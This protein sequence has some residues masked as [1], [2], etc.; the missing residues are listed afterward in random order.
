MLHR[1]I[2]YKSIIKWI[3]ISSVYTVH[4]YLFWLFTPVNN[5]KNS[6]SR[7][8]YSTIE[9]KTLDFKGNFSWTFWPVWLIFHFWH[10]P[11][12]SST[13]QLIRLLSQYAKARNNEILHW[14]W[15]VRNYTTRLQHL[16][17]RPLLKWMSEDLA[18]MFPCT[19]TSVS[20]S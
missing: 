8:L 1:N 10:A 6:S 7:W 12:N 5:S 14:L 11:A 19:L 9:N 13:V 17:S 20:F 16:A 4:M 15:N 18:F 3:F 2:M